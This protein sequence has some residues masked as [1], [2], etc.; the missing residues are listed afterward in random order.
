MAREVTCMVR[1]SHGVHLT[2][3]ISLGAGAS[4]FVKIELNGKLGSLDFFSFQ[5]KIA[6]LLSIAKTPLARENKIS[7][8]SKKSHIMLTQLLYFPIT[9]EL[10]GI[11]S[12]PVVNEHAY[13]LW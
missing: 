5:M 9:H 12:N 11:S 1:A 13:C 3:E 4:N 10:I 8:G 6:I 7:W 2:G